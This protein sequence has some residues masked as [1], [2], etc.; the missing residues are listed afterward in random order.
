MKKT[1]FIIFMPLF[2][3]SQQLTI[4]KLTDEVNSKNAEFN[5]MQYNDT[6]AFYTV[7]RELNGKFISEIFELNL[8]NDL[9]NNKQL[10]KYNPPSQNLAN[11]TFLDSSVTLFSIIEEDT[12]SS[13]V[14]YNND[15]I[16]KYVKIPNLN[17][18]STYNTQPFITEYNNQKVLYFVSDRKGGYGGLDIWLS[19]IDKNGNFGIPIN[20]GVYINSEADEITPF[21][22][23]HDKALYFS[24]NRLDG[25]G[26]FDIYKSYGALNLWQEP[27][28]MISMNS[29]KDD[30]Y[31]TFFDSSNGFFSSNREGSTYSNSEYCCNDIYSFKYS[32]EIVSKSINPEIMDYL[33]LNLFFHNDEP[34]SSTSSALTSMTYKEA[35]ISYFK[36]KNLYSSKNMEANFFFS[37]ILQANFNSLNRLLDLLFIE[38]NN[39]KS[40]ELQITGYASPLHNIK[41]NKN[42]SRRRISSFI[43]YLTQYNNGNFSKYILTKKLIINEVSFGESNSSNYVSD[44]VNDKKNSIYSIDAMLERKIQIVDLILK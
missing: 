16:D 3:F 21:Y 20:A 27:Q 28:N 19:M 9:W 25:K 4:K 5:F 18:N 42:L 35:Y 24:S 29:Q 32:G 26:N 10:S 37:N 39:G 6:V 7:A 12:I 38:L 44:D 40:F 15:K 14:L 11:I 41:Y 2:V 22:N 8:V 43:N 31:L 34:D 36:L 13:I 23:V 30:L 17:F 1:I 33:P